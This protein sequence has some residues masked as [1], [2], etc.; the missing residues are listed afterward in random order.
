MA[1]QDQAK[2][3]ARRIMSRLRERAPNSRQL[4]GIVL[5]LTAA[6]I[7]L[8]LGGITLA[9]AGLSLA[10]ATPLFI[11][12]SPILVPLAGIVAVG[13]G[14]FVSLSAAFVTACSAVAWLYNYVKGRHPVGADKIDA[15]KHKIADT[16]S[17]VS[18]KAREVA[19]EVGA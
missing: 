13:T 19:R 8:V 7:V 16:A 15:V 12:F 9:G 6:L 5:L 14:G 2:Q 17:H 4:L 18:E 10:L 3:Q 11:L 1:D